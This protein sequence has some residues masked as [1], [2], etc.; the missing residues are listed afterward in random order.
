M[1]KIRVEIDREAC[2]GFGACVELCPDSFY[3]SDS[4]GKSR[5]IG[6]KGITSGQGSAKDEIEVFE[7]GCYGHA[8][9]ACPFSA[10]RV[11]R[12]LVKN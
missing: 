1:N 10:I 3:L 12:L 7:L 6:G 2:Q 4:D 11:H 8:E 9:A 5:L